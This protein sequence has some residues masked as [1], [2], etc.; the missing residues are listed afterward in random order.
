MLR[1]LLSYTLL[2]LIN[3]SFAQENWVTLDKVNYSIKYPNN[4]ENKDIKDYPNVELLLYAGS[5]SAE[6]DGFAESINLVLEDLSKYNI[7]IEEYMISTLERLKN[8]YVIDVLKNEAI[9]TNHYVMEYS[10]NYND[11][12]IKTK[13]HCWLKNKIVYALSFSTTNEEFTVYDK[14]SNQI[15]NSFKLK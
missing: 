15:L 4:W 11:K 8:T 10:I 14:I 9:E 6:K 3:F 2:F 7:S 13:Q 5:E 12:I 1:L